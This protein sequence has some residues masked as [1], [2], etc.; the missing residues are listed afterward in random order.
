M[1][2]TST[3]PTIPAPPALPPG[4]DPKQVAWIR[5]FGAA[6]AKADAKAAQDEERRMAVATT[7]QQLKLDTQALAGLKMDLV[8]RADAG[9]KSRAMA[10]VGKQV[11]LTTLTGT[12]DAMAEFDTFHD[13]GSVETVDPAKM[14]AAYKS[15]EAVAQA[16]QALDGRLMALYCEEYGISPDDFEALKTKLDKK[17]AAP[18]RANQDGEAAPTEAEAAEAETLANFEQLA[19]KVE[20]EVRDEIWQPLVRQG[21]VPENLMPDRHSEV[22]RTFQ[23]TSEAYQERLEEYTA[24]MGDNANLIAKLGL[25]KTV[26]DQTKTVVTAVLEVVPGAP[27]VTALVKTAVEISAIVA[28]TGLEVAGK[29]LQKGEALDIADVASKGALAVLKSAG[30]PPEVVTTVGAGIKIALTGGQAVKAIMDGRPEDVV[31]ALGASLQQSLALASDLSGVPGIGIAGEA[32][33]MAVLTGPKA[34]AFVLAMRIKPVDRDAIKKALADL[35]DTT[36][37]NMGKAVSLA[38]DAAAADGALDKGKADQVSDAAALTTGGVGSLAKAAASD[39]PAEALVVALGGIASDCC[40]AY[41]PPSYGGIVAQ[42]LGAALTGGVALTAAVRAKDPDAAVAAFTG[43]LSSGL[44]VA[45]SRVGDADVALALGAA[46]KGTARLTALVTFRK[47]VAAGDVDAMEAAARQ[48]IDEALD[49]VLGAV[50]EVT[51][52]EDDADAVEDDAAG[53][54]GEDE[55]GKTQEALSETLE[56]QFQATQR[57][58]IARADAVIAAGKDPATV[59]KAKA[60]RDAAVT[61]LLERTV[62]LNTV[63]SDAADFA[64]MLDAN[65]DS[66]E[67]DG[68]TRTLEALIATIQRDRKIMQMVDAL[69]GMGVQAAAA[70]FAPVGIAMDFK[71]FAVETVKSVAHLRQL[72]IWKQNAK[73]ARNAVT[74]QVHAMLS[75]V[76]LEEDAVIEH[77]AKAALALLSAIGN[78]IATAGAHAAPAGVAIAASAKIGRAALELALTIKSAVEMEMAWRIYQA[79]LANPKDRKTV[80]NAIQKNPTMAKYALVW[81]AL[82]D[83]NPIAQ[84]ALKRC[85]L[86][87]AIIAK[88]SANV[89][90]VVEYLEVL[91]NDD[92]V[93]LRAVPDTSGWG[94]K[95]P[96]PELTLRAWTGFL[97][98]AQK[99]GSPKLKPGSGGAI[100]AAFGPLDKAQQALSKAIVVQQKVK[101][102]IAAQ[103]SAQIEADVAASAVQQPAAKPAT[104]GRAKAAAAKLAAAD[105]LVTARRIDVTAALAGIAQAAQAFRPVDVKDQPYERIVEWALALAALAQ[106]QAREL[107]GQDVGLVAPVQEAA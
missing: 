102:L 107:A 33:G 13:L 72:V 78:I 61:A 5:E 101:I 45:A 65:L 20:K 35:V 47:A 43:L 25:G 53:E 39:K 46:S 6:G 95:A 57:Q 11:T 3:S 60:E 15:L 75:R 29:V 106:L 63:A 98:L 10:L 42:S 23:G 4:V 104:S 37:R 100:T 7:T 90:G 92:P 97:D 22:A 99:K 50:G 76:G 71:T 19:A 31:A 67:E 27:A 34:K 80:R 105:A 18:K 32:V 69:L 73:D 51:L 91:Y 21:L 44:G 49:P 70:F 82:N 96:R 103:D 86:T 12:G 58:A 14:A 55:G 79:A 1:S 84:R 88:E 9:L 66:P 40:S 26:L 2:D 68:D 81:G 87:D 94:W 77:Q 48:V 89:Q 59:E 16:S 54:E 83:G 38:M 74:V 56:Q 28:S 93:V 17:K 24:Q 36:M 41:M 8:L 52:S 85:G 30:V 64:E 62:L